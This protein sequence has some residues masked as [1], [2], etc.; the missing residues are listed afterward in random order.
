MRPL[1]AS[2]S[3]GESPAGQIPTELGWGAGT[4]DRAASPLVGPGLLLGHGASP[5]S[6]WR[7]GKAMVTAAPQ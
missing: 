2:P 5:G 3:T 1:A 4:M 7:Q 6:S